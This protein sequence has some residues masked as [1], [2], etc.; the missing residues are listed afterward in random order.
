MCSVDE[1][2]L[3]T[4]CW[5]D[6]QFGYLGKPAEHSDN[7]ARLMVA[8]GKRV[9]VLPDSLSSGVY[10]VPRSR[11]ERL[12]P[13]RL[14]RRASWARNQI[15]GTSDAEYVRRTLERLDE[16][17]VNCLIAYWGTRPIGDVIA[18]KRHRP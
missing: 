6:I 8:V 13:R 11:W 9:A 10:D 3:Q 2:M 5:Q 7:L 18:V 12:L 15:F 4:M 1:V 16:H 17:R 14:G